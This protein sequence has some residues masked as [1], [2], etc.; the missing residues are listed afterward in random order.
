[1]EVYFDGEIRA[2]MI[3]YSVTWSDREWR[4]EG[5]PGCESRYKI[6]RGK[7]DGR[8]VLEILWDVEEK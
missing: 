5:F 1:M 2:T 7:L 6:S 4:D 8:K 3:I